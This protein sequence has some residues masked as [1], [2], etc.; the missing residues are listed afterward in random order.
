MTQSR[1]RNNKQHAHQWVTWRGRKAAK[2]SCGHC[3]GK[4]GCGVGPNQEG[5]PG[6]GDLGLSL[7]SEERRPAGGGN[8]LQKWGL[9]ARGREPP[10]QKGEECPPKGPVPLH[11]GSRQKVL[12]MEYCGGA[13]WRA[14]G[15]N[16][17]GLPRASSWWCCAPWVSPP[18]PVQPQI[19]TG[20]R[21]EIPG[22]GRFWKTS[23]HKST[24]IS[25]AAHRP[26]DRR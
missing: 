13:C 5:F 6:K 12:V 3:I 7:R 15:P 17:F 19:R 9:W 20:G 14:G 22:C 21:Q 25:G 24:G 2:G 11:R 10:Q 4:S 23:R 26:W 16:A 8:R 18:S 1:S